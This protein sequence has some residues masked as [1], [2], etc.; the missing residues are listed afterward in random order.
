VMVTS[1]PGATRFTVRLPVAPAGGAP[2]G[3]ERL[4]ARTEDE[5]PGSRR[6][7]ADRAGEP[8]AAAAGERSVAGR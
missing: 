1:E 8:G 7:E 5:A 3:D 4:S 2:T 6:S